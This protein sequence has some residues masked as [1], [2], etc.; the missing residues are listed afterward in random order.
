[1][2][3]RSCVKCEVALLCQSWSLQPLGQKPFVSR[4][5]TFWR[6]K[7]RQQRPRE[8]AHKRPRDVLVSLTCSGAIAR[9]PRAQLA[10]PSV[11]SSIVQSLARSSD[12]SVR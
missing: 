5:L 12:T 3:V 11:C 6:A 10:R 9:P 1:M 4:T 8:D 2:S 7:E